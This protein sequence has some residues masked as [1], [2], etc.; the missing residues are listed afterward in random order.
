MRRALGDE[1]LVDMWPSSDSPSTTRH[2]RSADSSR[3]C[4]RNTIVS[5]SSLLALVDGTSRTRISSRG[6]A[7]PGYFSAKYVR[8]T[9]SASGAVTL[10]FVCAMLPSW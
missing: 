3:R 7:G 5:K 9:A 6:A 8:S 10:K 2:T 1:P 4:T